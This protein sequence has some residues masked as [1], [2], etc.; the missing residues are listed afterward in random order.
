[1]SKGNYKLDDLETSNN[2]S[3]TTEIAQPETSQT[4]ESQTSNQVQD[5]RSNRAFREMR[6]QKEEAERKARMQDELIARLLANQPAQ[7]NQAPQIDHIAELDKLGDDDWIQAGMVKKTIK[8]V[9]QT[10][11]R[12]AYE[13]VDR[14]LQERDKADPFGKLRNKFSDFDDVVNSETL[15]LLEEH[16]PELARELADLKD[17]YKIGMLSYKNIKAMGLVEK[18]PADRRVKEVERKIEEN[19][20]TVQSPQVFDK[21]PMAQAFKMTDTEKKQLYR[22]MMDCASLSGGY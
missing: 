21:R 5:S 17:P 4:Q 18:A 14:R 22:E 20:K 16:D 19:K 15:G 12:K 1:M 3:A 6:L 13:A 2:P 7:T 10:S 9:E 11:E 8:Q